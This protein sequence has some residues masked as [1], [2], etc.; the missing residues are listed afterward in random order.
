MTLRNDEP[1]RLCD[2]VIKPSVRHFEDT[3]LIE[4][5][6]F[7]CVPA[8]G[9]IAVGYVM[10]VSVQHIVTLNEATETEM[11]SM[12][13]M[14]ALL[15]KM[16]PYCDG[17]LLFEHGGTNCQ[18]LTSC[19]KHFHLHVIPMERCSADE[20]M[21]RLDLDGE[22]VKLNNLTDLRTLPLR[23]GYIF[24]S[25]G[26]LAYC[27]FSDTVPSQLVRRVIAKM[28]GKDDEWNWVIF[29]HKDNLSKTIEL[30]C[31]T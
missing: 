17:Y 22:V 9:T 6:D 5:E 10:I 11:R 4:N 29:D 8:L 24:V 19:V 26:S 13:E 27:I 28:V 14:L 31:L 2:K 7:V 25:D 21:T 15:L 18:S 1:C 23:G 30:F 20:V 12:V 16:K 3:I